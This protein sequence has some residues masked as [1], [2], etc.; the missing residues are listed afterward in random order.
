MNNSNQMA[1]NE[2][3]SFVDK[4]KNFAKNNLYSISNFTL[5]RCIMLFSLS[6]V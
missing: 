4:M 3:I 5:C 6:N 1:L 2:P